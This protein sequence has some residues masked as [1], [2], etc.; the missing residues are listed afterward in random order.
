MLGR[1]VDLS[2]ASPGKTILDIGTGTGNLARLLLSRGAEVVGLDPS[3]KML[4]I[5]ADKLAGKQGLELKHVGEPF[6]SIPYQDS[7]FDAVVSTYSFHHV[8]P[9]KKRKCICE[10]LRVLKPG[11]VWV[12][13]DLIFQNED[14]EK[15]ALDSH[16][17]MEAEYYAR[18]DELLAV[19]RDKGLVL[20]SEQYTMITWVVWAEKSPAG[21]SA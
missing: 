14:E 21:A 3:R 11:G 5:A 18:I 10:M 1:V 2:G 7:M 9:D 8:H 17:W 13:G 4:E 16:D 12:L 19:F 20:K 15:E 6:L